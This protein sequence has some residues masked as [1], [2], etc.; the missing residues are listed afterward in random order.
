MYEP[1]EDSYL[2]CDGLL[3]DI[4]NILDLSP[5]L[6]VEIGPGTGIIGTYLC[7]L[8]QQRRKEQSSP[9]TKA[10]ATTEEN[11]ERNGL[12][13]IEVSGEN[14]TDTTIVRSTAS[15]SSLSS[16]SITTVL[17]NTKHFS[18]STETVS[19]LSSP[20]SRISLPQYL[21][22]D[23]NPYACQ[24]TLDTAK[25]NRINPYIEC[26]QGDLLY[27]ILHRCYHA[28]DILI[29]NPPYVPTPDNEVV[30]PTVQRTRLTTTTTINNNVASTNFFSSSS[31]TTA[32]V[33]HK[34]S[35]GTDILTGAW[36]GGTNGRIVID[37]LLPL[38]KKCLRLNRTIGYMIVVEDNQPENIRNFL[39]KEG[40][41][42]RILVS[43]KAKNEQLSVL[44]FWR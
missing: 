41:Q 20:L 23:M 31:S 43:T 35:V 28:I 36:A 44:K 39:A 38:L 4:E 34:V 22:I 10:P 24:I 11:K 29:F 7:Q 2:L 17:P 18:S 26:I 33:V 13:S 16:S 9:T 27:P 40:F 6:V 1:A 37:R 15:F 5:S 8:I 42:S 19:I 25:Q 30:H 32:A 21:A 3:K 12:P 14:T